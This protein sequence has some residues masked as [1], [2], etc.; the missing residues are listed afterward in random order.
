MNLTGNFNGVQHDT[1]P[2]Q[3]S[4]SVRLND[5]T[6]SDELESA[7]YVKNNEALTNDVTPSLLKQKQTGDTP[8]PTSSQLINEYGNHVSVTTSRKHKKNLNRLQ[9]NEI[10]G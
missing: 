7:Y 3:K 4:K 8:K 9:S 5:R 2:A 6:N 10:V 1:L